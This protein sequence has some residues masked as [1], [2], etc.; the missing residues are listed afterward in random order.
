MEK[1]M[2]LLCDPAFDAGTANPLK[3][4]N[5]LT[6]AIVQQ[7]HDGMAASEIDEALA[8]AARRLSG[9]SPRGWFVA[10]LLGVLVEYGGNPDITGGGLLAWFPRIADGCVAFYKRCAELLE[11]DREVAGAI[12]ERAEQAQAEGAGYDLADYIR[13]EGWEAVVKRCHDEINAENRHAC[14]AQNCQ[15]RY[16]L[17]L[18][19]H[20]SRSKQLRALARAKPEYLEKAWDLYG[21]MLGEGDLVVKMLRVQD[22]EPL[23]VLH[24]GER[25]GYAV[26]ISGIA[27]NFELN[28]LIMQRLIGDP[29]AGWLTG[30]ALDKDIADCEE[31]FTAQYNLWNWPGLQPDGTV[32]D[33]GYGR[34]ERREGESLAQAA[35]RDW[36]WNEGVPADIL[37][38]DGTRVVLLGPP[39]YTRSF[40][41]GRLFPHME[42]EFVVEKKLTREEVDDCL[43]EIARAGRNG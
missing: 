28:L 20:L 43:K 22:D 13:E 34:N 38:F 9:V 12:A 5:D 19:A 37:R 26:R 16:Q 31:T 10:L 29:Q 15:M 18:M 7:L 41:G 17:A 3:E 23:L 6:D 33:D 21:A 8:A 32:P 24:P 35:S 11:G 27:V 1:M 4:I 36:I 30:D 25:K 40:Y 39:P 42:P 2:D 14:R